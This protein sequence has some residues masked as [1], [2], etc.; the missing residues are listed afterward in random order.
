MYSYSQPGDV[1]NTLY[2]SV[3]NPAAAAGNTAS[4]YGNQLQQYYAANMGLL[5][6]S[7]NALIQQQYKGMGHGRSPLANQNA[8][9]QM[10]QMAYQPA[11]SSAS[12]YENYI[13]NLMSHAATTAMQYP[14]QDHPSAAGGGGGGTN[15]LPE[16]GGEYRKDFTF[17]TKDK[18]QQEDSNQKK[19]TEITDNYGGQIPGWAM[20]PGNNSFASGP[21]GT[22]THMWTGTTWQEIKDPS[23]LDA[24]TQQSLKSFNNIED[25]LP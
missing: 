19:R 14:R 15:Y 17:N 20:A 22:G 11:V 25:F 23:K 7:L 2:G 24:Q 8:S 10:M 5:Q 4:T 13:R 9:L 3:A 16:M 18:N 6:P 21:S 1:W 12:A